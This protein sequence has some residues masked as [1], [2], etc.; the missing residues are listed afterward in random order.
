VRKGS[1]KGTQPD[2]GD[3]RVRHEAEV[4]QSKSCEGRFLHGSNVSFTDGVTLEDLF[5]YV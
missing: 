5:D 2:K 4:L 3:A 1:N